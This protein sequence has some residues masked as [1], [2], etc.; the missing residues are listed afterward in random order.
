MRSEYQEGALAEN[1]KKL[2]TFDYLGRYRIQEVLI[3][4]GAGGRGLKPLA[5]R[6]ESKTVV[7]LQ[8]R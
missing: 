5:P 3:A 8:L 6:R 2:P 7:S 1:S 4:S